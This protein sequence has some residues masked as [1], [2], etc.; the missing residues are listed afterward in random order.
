MVTY[1]PW[2]RYPRTTQEKR[3]NQPEECPSRERKLWRPRRNLKRLP[4]AYDDFFVE[5]SGK[6]CW[7]WRR[8]TQY[9]A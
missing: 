6:K 2:L 8:R 1:T 3:A 4:D 7:K 5:R 9:K